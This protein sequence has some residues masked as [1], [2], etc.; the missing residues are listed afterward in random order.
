[1]NLVL[2]EKVRNLGDIGDQ[3]SVRS[4]YARNYL[5]PKGIAIRATAEKIA[6]FEARKEQLLKLAQ[7]KLEKMQALSAKLEGVNIAITAKAADEG[8]LF[9]SVGPREIA[10]SLKDSGHDI[11]KS[12]I[13]MPDGPI[14]QLGEF[15]IKLQLHIDIVV[16]I[17]LSI[18]EDESA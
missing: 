5:I 2:Q 7:E 18:K 14:R 17:K 3:V 10:L 1:M 4:G 9:G 13:L 8:R 16:D 11:S 15:D 12:Q 6:K